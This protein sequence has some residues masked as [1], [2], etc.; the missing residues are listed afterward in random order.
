MKPI[1]DSL[2]DEDWTRIKMGRL[3]INTKTTCR[4]LAAQN[5]MMVGKPDPSEKIH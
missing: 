3:P 2:D 5:L 4:F 1:F